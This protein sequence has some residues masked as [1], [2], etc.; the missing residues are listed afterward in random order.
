LSQERI[1]NKRVSQWHSHVNSSTAFAEV[2]DRLLASAQPKPDDVCVDLG[3]GTGFVTLALA[4]QVR[5]VL[6]IDIAVGMTEALE[7]RAAEAHLAN[8]STLATDLMTLRLPPASTDLIVSSYVL[9]HLPNSG[10]RALVRE[11]AGWL[12][13]GGRLVI[14][15]MMFGRGWNKRDREVLRQKAVALAAKG[16][17]G[18][19][20]IAKNLARYGLGV[21]HEHPAS[22]EFWVTALE[23][24]GF[25]M[26]EFE[27]IVAEAGLVTGIKP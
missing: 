22:A 7:A 8:V 23:D 26:V 27:A 4:P 17:G 24:A 20:R 6:S 5:S 16:P 3:A 1:W 21:G 2:L 13:P 9:H 19:W 25:A 11:A 12:R 18:M 14:A 10:K 15:D